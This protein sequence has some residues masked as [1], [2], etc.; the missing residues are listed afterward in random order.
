LVHEQ[1]GCELGSDWVSRLRAIAR[2]N[3]PILI[4]LAIGDE[5]VLLLW[6][7]ALF[8]VDVLSSFRFCFWCFLFFLFLGLDRPRVFGRQAR[9]RD[10]VSA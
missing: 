8:G 2:A 1:L 9:P 10:F 4:G 5:E 3:L 7:F 6:G